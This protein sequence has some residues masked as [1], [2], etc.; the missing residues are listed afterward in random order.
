MLMIELDEQGQPLPADRPRYAK[1][2]M[3]GCAYRG[4]N[5]MVEAALA[6]GADVD[7]VDEPTGLSALHLAVGTNNLK[8]ARMLV[9]HY[10]A[11]FFADR[12]GRWPSVIAIEADVDDDLADYIMDAEARFLGLDDLPR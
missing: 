12:S 10:R 7:M 11:S 2:D 8:L 1:D 6:G 9:E 5:D 3:L 4:E